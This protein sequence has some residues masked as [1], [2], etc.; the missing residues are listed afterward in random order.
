MPVTRRFQFQLRYDPCY[1][2]LPCYIDR[3]MSN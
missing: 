1:M 2:L 3:P